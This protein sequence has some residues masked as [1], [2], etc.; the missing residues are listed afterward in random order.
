MGSWWSNEEEEE[1]ETS[2]SCTCDCLDE[3]SP[4]GK[5]FIDERKKP[6]KKTI[7][8]YVIKSAMY[9]RSLWKH[10]HFCDLQNTRRPFV[11]CCDEPSCCGIQFC[12]EFVDFPSIIF[13]SDCCRELADFGRL[14]G[15][16]HSTLDPVFSVNATTFTFKN[17]TIPF[18]LF[19]LTKTA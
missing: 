14:L 9:N 13:C 17:E 2:L 4:F 3:T 16:L 12:D 7:S 18:Y 10:I 1:P 5:T 6:L 15:T 8:W 11:Q 19:A